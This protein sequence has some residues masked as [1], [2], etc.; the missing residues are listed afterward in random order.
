MLNRFQRNGNRVNKTA[1]VF[2]NSTRPPSVTWT[3]SQRLSELHQ[4]CLRTVNECCLNVNFLC[5]NFLKLNSHSRVVENKTSKADCHTRQ[6]T[7]E[8]FESTSLKRWT[9]Q[10]TCASPPPQH[11]FNFIKIKF[12]THL[13][14][15]LSLSLVLCFW[16][17][18]ERWQLVCR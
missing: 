8:R 18:R 9:I 13:C 2:A 10:H 16:L 12:W 14:W 3:Y 5:I 17:R 4:I 15:F 11:N 7:P 1:F 6:D